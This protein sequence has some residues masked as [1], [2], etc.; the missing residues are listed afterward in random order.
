MT[1]VHGTKTITMNSLSL[2]QMEM[3]SSG[4][5]QEAVSCIGGTASW[6]GSI[7]ALALIPATAGLGVVALAI[8]SHQANGVLMGVSCAKWASS[9]S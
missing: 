2:N 3:V 8:L 9:L 5:W 7:A 6:I 4:T 1:G